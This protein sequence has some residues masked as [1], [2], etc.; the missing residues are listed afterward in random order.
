MR[1]SQFVGCIQFIKYFSLLTALT[2][3]IMPDFSEI[4]IA[5]AS[6]P[7]AGTITISHKLIK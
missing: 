4:A 3:K 6:Q 5:I 1:F 2:M 7:V